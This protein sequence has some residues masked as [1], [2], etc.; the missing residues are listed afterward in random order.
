L[1]IPGVRWS[2][3]RDAEGNLVGHFGRADQ[4]DLEFEDAAEIPIAPAEVARLDNDP[5]FPEL[6]R[7]RFE[8]AGGR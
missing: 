8:M 1:A 6:G 5:N 7:I 3:P 4:P 2:G